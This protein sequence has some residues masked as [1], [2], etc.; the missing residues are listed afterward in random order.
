MSQQTTLDTATQ[1]DTVTCEVCDGTGP[2]DLCMRLTSWQEPVT[3]DTEWCC[4]WCA[5]KAFKR[6]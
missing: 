3:D 2:K 5:S 1:E 6:G 4:L